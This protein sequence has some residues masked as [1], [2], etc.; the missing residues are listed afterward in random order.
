VYPSSWALKGVQDSGYT[1]N[2]LS[3]FNNYRTIDFSLKK[4]SH[5]NQS[6]KTK[7]ILASKTPTNLQIATEKWNL[8]IQSW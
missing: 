3:P 4:I 6:L 2:N 5:A 8:D 7:A 1:S